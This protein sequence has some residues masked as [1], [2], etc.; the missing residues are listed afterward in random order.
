MKG[1][2][3][4]FLKKVASYISNGWKAYALVM[5]EDWD[6]APYEAEKNLPAPRQPAPAGAGTKP[7]KPAAATAELITQTDVD[8]ITNNFHRLGYTPEEVPARV[9]ELEKRM[10]KTLAE[11][12]AGEARDI[13]KRME[14]KIAKQAAEAQAAPSDEP[15]LQEVAE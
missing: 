9:A 10:G 8:Q 6:Q 11:F 13:I 1:A 14:D 4:N 3:T 7:T 5:D 2:K 15:P 12:T